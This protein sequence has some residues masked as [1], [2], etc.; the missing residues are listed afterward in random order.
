VVITSTSPANT[1][2]LGVE[3]A[4][5]DAES[6]PLSETALRR[7]GG[8]ELATGAPRDWMIPGADEVF[9]GIYTRAGGGAS[10]VIA[11][12]SALAGEGKTT[13]SI[14]LA[15]TIAQDFPDRRVLLVETEL[16]HPVIARDFELDPTP[17]LAEC[18]AGDEPVQLAYRATNLDNL[19]LV[20]AGEP[21]A[22]PGRLLRS[23]RMTAVTEE[24]RRSHDIVILDVPAVLANSDAISLIDLADGIIFVVRAGATPLSLFNRALDQF[25]EAKLRGVVMNDAHSSIPRWL[26]QMCG[27]C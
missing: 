13:L 27:L 24:M 7:R 18:L 16:Q 17:G 10:E 5:L 21:V 23:S 1:S 14:G 6:P 25:D 11:V 3:A 26:R 9:R 8:G 19:H 12:C 15:V 20:P 2:T 22:N 4:Q